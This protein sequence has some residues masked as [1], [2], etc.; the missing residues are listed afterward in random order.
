[1]TNIIGGFFGFLS[2]AVF[3]ACVAGLIV[4]FVLFPL[5]PVIAVTQGLSYWWWKNHRGKPQPPAQEPEMLD[6]LAD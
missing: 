5:L 6:A 4:M 2:L 3:L 1:M